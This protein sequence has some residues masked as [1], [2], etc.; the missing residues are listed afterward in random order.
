MSNK[1][2]K[3]P[4]KA[5]IASRNILDLLLKIK[6]TYILGFLLIISA[7]LIGVLYTKVAYLE[8]GVTDGG[9][10]G[11]NADL[12]QAPAG[13][14]LGGKVDL[15]KDN[16]P[17]LGNSDAKVKIVEFSDFQCPFCE[18]FY[19]ENFAQL[20]KDYIDTGKVQFVFRHYPLKEI[21]PNAQKAAEAA[22]CAN[23]QGN[24]WDYHDMLFTKLSDWS[25]IDGASALEKYVEYANSIGLNGEEL[26]NCVSTDE[27]ADVINNDLE[28]GKKAG[29]NGTP[30]TYI[31]GQLVSSGGQSAGALPYTELKKLIDEA[32][33]SN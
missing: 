27:M 6:V 23:E 7:F 32:L 5:K 24:F 26:R 17:A 13:Y 25:S 33:S 15:G 3:L 12:P 18:R 11:A 16:L 2:A 31:N 4:S 20:K 21:H 10:I 30:T 19:N 9:Q 1:A 29:V 28:A 14:S 22:Q 8:K